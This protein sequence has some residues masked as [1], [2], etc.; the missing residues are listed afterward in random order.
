MPY[1]LDVSTTPAIFSSESGVFLAAG[2]VIVVSVV[3]LVVM[4]KRKQK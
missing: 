1:L 2:L 3:V 4:R